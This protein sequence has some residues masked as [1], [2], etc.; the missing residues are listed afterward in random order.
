MEMITD[1]PCSVSLLHFSNAAAHIKNEMPFYFGDEL[2]P[3]VV[4][5][6]GLSLD[7]VKELD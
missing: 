2:N 1:R 5:A 6:V 3:E 4:N 7:F